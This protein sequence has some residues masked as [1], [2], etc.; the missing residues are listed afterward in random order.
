MM[1][2]SGTGKSVVGAQVADRLGWVFAEGD[3]FHSPANV[4]K[5][6]SGHPLTDEDRWPWLRDIAAWIGAHEESGAVVSCSA[7]RRP[8]RDLLGAGHP[9]V[10]FVHLTASAEVLDQRMR[11]R[12]GH[13]MPPSLLA[14]QLET[15]EPL[16]ADE[17]GIAINEEG[18]TAEET[19][20]HVLDLTRE[21]LAEPQIA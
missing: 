13:Y 6:R 14:S 11:S 2:V 7:L 18:R 15:L 1:G 12:P 5:M 10:R 19:V 3:D 8:Y 17:P 20:A 16:E 21:W 4:E 9:A